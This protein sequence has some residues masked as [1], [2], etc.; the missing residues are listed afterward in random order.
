MH[1]HT[2][3]E[4]LLNYVDLLRSLRRIIL[5]GE[6]ES[7]KQDGQLLSGWY[8]ESTS[9]LAAASWTGLGETPQT[10]VMGI[11][12]MRTS[13]GSTWLLLHKQGLKY[14]QKVLLCNHL[15][16]CRNGFY[17]AHGYMYFGQFCNRNGLRE[18]LG[19]PQSPYGALLSTPR[20]DSG[21]SELVC[22]QQ[23]PLDSL[24]GCSKSLPGEKLS[25]LVKYFTVKAVGVWPSTSHI[26]PLNQASPI[27]YLCRSQLRSSWS[28]QGMND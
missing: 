13:H 11:S 7:L 2:Q 15:F 28:P 16:I 5:T 20:E 4:R 26:S 18:S 9:D 25:K 21:T 3:G 19:K 10:A 23:L 14:V 8:W 6:I 22:V 12:H 27:P 24:Q 1:R 17:W